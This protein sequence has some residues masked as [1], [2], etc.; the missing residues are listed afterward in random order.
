M[1]YIND[2]IS[3]DEKEISIRFVQSSGPGGQN[4][5]KNATAVQLRFD[6]RHSPALNEDTRQR[7]INLAGR[8]INHAGEL[9]IDARRFRNQS[10]NRCDAIERLTCLLQKAAHAPRQRRQTAIPGSMRARRLESK[11]RRSLLKRARQSFQDY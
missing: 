7:L 10:L 8:Q 6:V 1:I 4:I 3:L 5:N 2:Y 9:I 11:R